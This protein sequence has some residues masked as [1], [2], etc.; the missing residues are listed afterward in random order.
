MTTQMKQTRAVSWPRQE[1]RM[2]KLQKNALNIEWVNGWSG[3]DWASK[4]NRKK[5]ARKTEKTLNRIHCKNDG[6]QWQI[7]RKRNI[8]LWQQQQRIPLENSI[9]SLIYSNAWLS[10]HK[11]TWS[12]QRITMTTVWMKW[13]RTEKYHQQQQRLWKRKIPSRQ[14]KN[15]KW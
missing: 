8:S 14:I 3:W 11:H 15:I 2:V 10:H 9:S 4:W 12:M 1:E 7:N 6:K 5:N 13:H